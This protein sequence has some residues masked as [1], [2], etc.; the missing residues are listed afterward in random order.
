MAYLLVHVG[1]TLEAHNYGMAIVWTS[2]HQVQVSTMEEAVET[3]SIHISSGPD[4]PY[5][6][7]QQ[8]EGSSHTPPQGQTFRHLAPRKG[9]GEPLWAD[10][11]T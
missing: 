5:A 7:T 6:L 9:R 3:L 11:P 4:W 8:Y 2:P 1:G 10:K